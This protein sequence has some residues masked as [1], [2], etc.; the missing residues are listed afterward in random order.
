MEFSSVGLSESQAIED[1]GE[2]KVEVMYI[3]MCT[4]M[5]SVPVCRNI[6]MYMCTYMM[7]W[8]EKKERQAPEANEKMK[9][10][11]LHVHV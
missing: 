8:D 10:E 9:N 7:T 2:E 4:I 11:P 3:C 1:Y 5:L 6:Y